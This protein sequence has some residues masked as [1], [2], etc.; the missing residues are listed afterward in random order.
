MEI[1]KT[2][3]LHNNKNSIEWWKLIP[4]KRC[5][6]YAHSQ[7]RITKRPKAYQHKE[8]MER[9]PKYNLRR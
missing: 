6:C 7:E 2:I 1:E 5:V 4:E 8:N 9:N 3:K